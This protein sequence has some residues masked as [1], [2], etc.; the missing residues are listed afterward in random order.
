MLLC[1][2]VSTF[3]K[4]PITNFEFCVEAC[5]VVVRGLATYDMCV[6]GQRCC[7]ALLDWLVAARSHNAKVEEVLEEGGVRRCVETALKVEYWA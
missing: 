7:V 6:C 1:A 3:S 2:R 4:V 5:V